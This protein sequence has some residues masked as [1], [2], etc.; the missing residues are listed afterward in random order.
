M[1]IMQYKIRQYCSNWRKFLNTAFIPVNFTELLSL[2]TNCDTKATSSPSV[3]SHMPFGIWF[4]S[5]SATMYISHVPLW[6]TSVIDK[7]KAITTMEVEV[8]VYLDKKQICERSKLDTVAHSQ[9]ISLL[10]FCNVLFNELLCWEISL[11][12]E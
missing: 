9:N 10:L 1:T 11:L 7:S 4:C 8:A 3:V 2:A 6:F 12:P 5:L